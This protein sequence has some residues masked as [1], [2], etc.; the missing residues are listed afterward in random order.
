MIL[1]LSKAFKDV[2]KKEKLNYEDLDFSENSLQK[3]RNL[4]NSSAVKCL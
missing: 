2:P 1:T 3:L 4:R